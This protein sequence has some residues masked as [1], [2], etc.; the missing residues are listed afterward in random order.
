MAGVSLVEFDDGLR[1]FASSGIEVRFLHEEIFGSGCYAFDLP[2]RPFVIDVGANIGMFSLF[3]KLHRP[4]ATIL[5]FEPVPE[6]AAV[7]R[8]NIELHRLSAVDLR[9][10]ALG[11]Q[12]EQDV[13]FTYYPALPGNSTL[14]PE[15]KGQAK[16]ALAR[17]YSTRL[18]ERLYQGRRATVCVQRLSA[19]LSEDRP[20]DLLK[21]D[22]EGAELDVL[23]G[24]A[25]RHW[26]LIR[27]VSLEV[28][29]QDGR[30]DRICELLGAR[31]LPAEARI[32]PMTDPAAGD[33][34]VHA[35]RPG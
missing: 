3:V 6:T 2:A 35:V 23:T 34:L 28:Y 16:A 1:V 8:R 20:V 17:L 10:I 22:V 13:P 33:Y 18:A 7:F 32:A 14:Y 26:P 15:Q 30:L 21:V 12:P 29:D 25:D 31:G 24:I 5:A 27:R 19:Y 4:D 11:S 9:E